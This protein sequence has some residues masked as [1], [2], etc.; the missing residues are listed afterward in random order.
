MPA[1]PPRAPLE[2]VS[3]L[4]VL[5]KAVLLLVIAASL[6]VLVS[7]DLLGQLSLY[8]H[9]FPGR[10]RLP[11]GEDQQN[12]YNLSLY[13]LT[14]MFASHAIQ[15]APFNGDVY[16]VFLLGD[17][18]VWGT[19]L[20]PEQTLAGQLN[21][22]HLH[23]C[24]KPA[25]FYNFG[26]PTLSL[27]KDLM[28]LDRSLQYRPDRILWLVTLESFAKQNQLAAPLVANNPAIVRR[29]ISRFGLSL[30]TNDPAFVRTTFLART[31]FGQRRNLADLVRLQLYGVMWAATGVD[32][33]Y[34]SGLPRAQ[35]DLS[36]DP[37][38]HG[39]QPPAL[40]PG[41]LSF[42]VL[43]AGFTAAGDVP[44]SLI[45]EPILVSQGANSDIRYNF[46][47]PRWAYDQYRTLL[48]QDAQQ[49][50]WSYQ[51]L[52]DLV[53]PEHFTNTAI[54]L[55]PSAEQSLAYEVARE[56]SKSPCP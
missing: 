55:D 45:N 41:S 24:G 29:L 42:D 35:T 48:A 38:F 28:I 1:S 39:Q 11:F 12:A 5:L 43:E 50:K 54:H 15:A 36:P 46:F 7:P 56:L 6:F 16:R 53:P 8:N 27:T 22:Q 34:P 17:S 51:D 13:N 40:D 47:Y 14:A 21:A 49:H 30:D 32:Q 52:W 20:R 25:R 23:L 33:V 2:N 18:S 19:L 31:L 4:R 9:V 3:P 10:E 37:G 26:Y 44:I